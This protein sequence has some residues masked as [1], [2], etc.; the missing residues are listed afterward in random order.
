MNLKN[1]FFF[2]R[3]FL[4]VIPSFLYA[5]S[6]DSSILIVKKT[7]DFKITGDGAAVN[8]NNTQWITLS[9]KDSSPVTYK[10]Q[11]KVLYSDSGIYC[12]YNC[13]DKKITSTLRGDFLDLWHEDVVEAFFWTSENLPIYFEYELSPLNYELPILI[14]NN[15]GDFMGWLPWHYTE[16]RKTRHATHVKKNGETVISWSAEVFIPFT[17]LKSLQNV[18][19]QRGT[20][21]RANF[22]RIDHDNGSSYWYWQPT[23][24][25]FHDYERFGTLVFE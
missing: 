22:Y 2:V 9:E 19:P 12:L 23:R 16:E 13:E 14:P 6:K 20:R 18:P 21:W 11:F 24:T 25:N 5:Q 10:T 7:S 3:C 17:L 15:K 4:I 8:W 1:I